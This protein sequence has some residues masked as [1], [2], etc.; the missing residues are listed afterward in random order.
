ML[1]AF[2]TQ[3]ALRALGFPAKKADV[4]RRLGIYG[5]EG[6]G[7]VNQ[8][9]FQ[10]LMT[11]VMLGKDPADL[12]SNAFRLFDT[13]SMGK[14]S[15]ED[16]RIIAGELGQQVEDQDLLG[17]IEEFDVDKDGCINAEEFQ[18]IM[19]MAEA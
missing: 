12:L 1:R 16:L 14:I 17:M 10:L 13:Q 4:Q 6:S 11:E 15:P 9:Q 2:D 7:V 5:T 18:R 8:Q 3:A 19:H